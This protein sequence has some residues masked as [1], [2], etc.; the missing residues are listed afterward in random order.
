MNISYALI[1]GYSFFVLIS[2]GLSWSSFV[3]LKELACR[4]SHGNCS[5]I[6]G[7]FDL[8]STAVIGISSMNG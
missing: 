4:G 8:V 1:K 2:S 6:V 7:I 3:P 5:F